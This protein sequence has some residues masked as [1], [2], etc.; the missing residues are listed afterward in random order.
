ME[1]NPTTPTYC[2]T[3][4][5]EIVDGDNGS[6]FNEGECL[7][8]EYTRYHYQPDLLAACGLALEEILQWDEIMG[9]SADPRTAA[10]IKALKNATAK[11]YGK[12]S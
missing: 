5:S 4:G 7:S 2:R 1:N 3:C 10:A 8:C 11:A 6:A 12:A 9:G